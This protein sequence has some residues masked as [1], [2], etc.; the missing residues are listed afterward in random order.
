MNADET[1][2]FI[3][4]CVWMR[5]LCDCT[6]CDSG[7][8]ATAYGFAP[9]GLAKPVL[10]LWQAGAELDA[11]P[12]NELMAALVTNGPAVASGSAS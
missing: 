12:V 9:A 6:D 4:R 10:K 8:L 5:F 7:A 11:L 3:A 1:S 2:E